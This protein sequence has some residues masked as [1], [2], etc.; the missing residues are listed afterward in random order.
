MNKILSISRKHPLEFILLFL[1]IGLCFSAPGFSTL[2]NQIN[3]LRN[4]STQGI[5][6]FGMTMVIISGE[7]DL[8]VGSMVAFSGCVLA[9]IVK[10]LTPEFGSI[11]AVLIGIITVLVIGFMIGYG[12]GW[13]R[14]WYNVPTFIISLA[15]L[16]ILFG[17][18]S[19]VTKGFPIASFPEWFSWIG[20]GYI[21]GIPVPAIF[22]LSIFGLTYF[23]MNFTVFGRSIYAVG[24]N[25]KAARIS[26]INV[27]KIKMFSLAF[28][29][30]LAS[31][32]GIIVSSQIL[33]GN[34][35]TA[36]GWELD[37]IASVI[38]GGASLSGGSGRIWGTFIGVVFLG[39]IFNGMTLMNISEYWQYVVRGSLILGAILINQI[40]SGQSLIN[41]K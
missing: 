20:S 7:I 41:R 2:T 33:S 13:I 22:F 4:I 40:Q 14:Y 28:T 37:I 8:S 23:I 6:A 25:L 39:V 18:A 3:I 10:I 21:L 31:L 5:I 38:I 15:M 32:S 27:W 35:A 19:L 17:S 30:L 12:V 9:W 1:F 26:G 24:G 29:S 11:I 34:P 16:T 36:R